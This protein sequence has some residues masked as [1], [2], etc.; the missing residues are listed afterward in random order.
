LRLLLG[1]SV[2]LLALPAPLLEAQ[3]QQKRVLLL[4]GGRP[5]LPGNM[6]VNQAIR[7]ALFREFAT[8]VDLRFEFAEPPADPDDP[9]QA[10]RD[11]LRAKYAGQRFDLVIALANYA[12]T[13][14]RLHARELFPDVPILC[15]GDESVIEN[16]GAGPPFTAVLG[17]LDAGAVLDFILRLRPETRRLVVVSGG[18][19]FDNLRLQARV[20]EAL[21]PH[22]G[23]VEISYLSRLPL[24]DLKREVARLPEGTAILY[25]SVSGDASGRR[26]VNVDVLAALAEVANAPMFGLVESNLGAGIV[27]GV[28]LSQQR[29]SDE[30]AKVAIRVL[31]G[32]RVERIP[33]VISPPI[34][35][36]DWRQL[37]RWGIPEDRLPPDTL[38]H[39]REQSLWE[40]YRWRVVGIAVVCLAQAM[41]IAAL[42]VA[43][44]RSR[45]AAEALRH[46]QAIADEQRQELAHLGRVAI[47]GQLSETLAHELNQPLAAIVANAHAA[48]RL[49][50]RDGQRLDEVLSSLQDIVESGRRAGDLIARQRG[51]LKR[52]Q[53]HAQHLGLNE[54]AREVLDLAHSDLL[55]QKVSVAIETDPSLPEV[56]GD[57]AQLQQVLLNLIFNACDS[58]GKT[59][60]PERKLR[61]TTSHE[62]RG[63][64]HLQ[65]AD[66]GPGI[67]SADLERIFEPFVT[68]KPH[69]LGLGLAISRTIIANHGGRMWATNEPEGGAAFH[70]V[71]PG[72]GSA[73]SAQLPQ[74]R[75]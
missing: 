68:S 63:A 67:P 52:G 71:L 55:R 47:L 12:V 17:R 41:L 72:V 34:P 60:A 39:Y 23:R 6:A 26:L 58:M 27:G 53:S 2:L 61:V 13:F 57:R 25:S 44:A 49:L 28:L 10:L 59:P 74:A 15:W 24:E 21:Q 16:W 42:L 4:W 11:F 29:L 20:R 70:V 32:E 31:R 19:A 46:A 65:V 35:M 56:A 73:A 30:T 54:V 75:G 40:T 48:R 7:T 9:Q 66:G 69:G 36:V 33:I 5:D 62:P 50:A 22:A 8:D 18:S 38:V 43:R 14:T 3:P 45:R 51:L 1:A 37:R 64:V